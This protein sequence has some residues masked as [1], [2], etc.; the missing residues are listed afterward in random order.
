MN[1]ASQTRNAPRS[2]DMFE[3]FQGN[4]PWNLATLMTLNTGGQISEIDDVLRPLKAVATN[5]DNA[6]NERFCLAWRAAAQKVEKAAQL[7]E[8]NGNLRA[9]GGKYARAATYYFSAERQT[10]I[11]DPDRESLYRAFLSAFS[12]FVA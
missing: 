9:A 5:A 8:Q 7:D 1:L 6:A 12:K 3:Y 11:H 10:S 2:R 4:Y